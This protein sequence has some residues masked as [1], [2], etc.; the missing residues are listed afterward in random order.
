MARKG[1][2]SRLVTTTVDAK[3]VLKSMGKLPKEV[4]ELIRDSNKLNADRLAR[5]ARSLISANDPPQAAL[6]KDTIQGKRD[7][8]IK[9]EAG[10]IKRVGRPYK[11]SKSNGRAYR[12]PAGALIHGAEYGSS[13]KPQDRRGRTMGARFVKAH[14]ELGN[15]LNPAL[16]KF[17]PE[18]IQIWSDTIQREIQKR[19]LK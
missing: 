4:Q 1:F 11:S 3:E 18:L 8:N 16:R 5:E 15:F 14:N 6:I 2:D 17:A 13:G 19:G 7:R 10:G 9:V 12:A